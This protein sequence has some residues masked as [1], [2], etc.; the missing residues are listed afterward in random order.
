PRRK[1]RN[2]ICFIP[3]LRQRERGLRF[4][5]AERN[6]Q[7]RPA[8]WGTKIIDS[9]RLLSSN[10]LSQ[11]TGPMETAARG[12]VVKQL[13]SAAFAESDKTPAVFGTIEEAVRRDGE[14]VLAVLEHDELTALLARGWV[15]ETNRTI[16]RRG[17]D[18]LGVVGHGH[19]RDI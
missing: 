9:I 10:D 13:Q 14:P 4:F 6:A 11:Q 7:H 5:V 8:C 2:A 19:A 15:P 16:G 18:L 12:I 3:H 1:P 17:P